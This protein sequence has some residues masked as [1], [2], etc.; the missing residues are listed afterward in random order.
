MVRHCTALGNISAPDNGLSSSGKWLGGAVSPAVEGFSQCPPELLQLDGST[1]VG[2]VRNQGHTHKDDMRTSPAEMVY[3]TPLVLPGQ[4]CSLAGAPPA[5]EPFLH[6]LWRAM[7]NLQPVP[8]SAYCKVAAKHVPEVLKK[9]PMVW[10]R[11]DG[12]RQPLTP[13]YEEPFCVLERYP[14]FFK[15]QLGEKQDN[16]SIDRLKPATVTEGMEP[17][18]PRKRGEARQKPRCSSLRGGTSST[19]AV[20]ATDSTARGY[21]PLRSQ[22]VPAGSFGYPQ[23]W[24]AL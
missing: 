3:G 7:E 24:V 2:H 19:R 8:T 14:K 17:A 15:I 13:R 1:T 5:T 16:I 20:S 22:G 6:D 4:F 23:R 11:R 12:Y 18:R 9:C 21:Y 10:I